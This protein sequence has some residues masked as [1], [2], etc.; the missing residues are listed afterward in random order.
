MNE[1]KEVKVSEEDTIPAYK[2]KEPTLVV[3]KERTLLYFSSRVDISP[4]IYKVLRGA[5][6]NGTTKV[7]I[8]KSRSGALVIPKR[9]RKQVQVWCPD[10]IEELELYPG[11]YRLFKTKIQNKE[12]LTFTA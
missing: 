5:G 3:N 2:Y 11:R 10:L 4:G 7:A 6:D 12:A 8:V 1:W 9:D